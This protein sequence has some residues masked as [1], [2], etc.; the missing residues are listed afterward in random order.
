MEA[1]PEPRSDADVLRA[2]IAI[3]S[4]RLPTGWTTQR[5]E[6]RTYPN[7]GFDGLLSVTA[8][9]GTSATLVLEAK[10]LVEGR[11]IAI[12][13]DRMAQY[14]HKVPGGRGVVVA[15]YLSPSVRKRLSDAGLSYV[16]A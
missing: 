7:S 10:R 8:P 16:D 2:G 6:G 11:D 5:L 12:L 14:S 9:D 15:R 1:L 13:Q 3:L 4:D